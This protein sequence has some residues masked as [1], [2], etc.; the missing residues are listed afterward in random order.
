MKLRFRRSIKPPFGR[1]TVTNRNITQS[2]RTPIGTFSNPLFSSSRSRKGT[3]NGGSSLGCL[4][5]LAVCLFAA[6]CGFWGLLEFISPAATSRTNNAPATSI[7]VVDSDAAKEATS[8]ARNL[9]PAPA[10]SPDATDALQTPT[11]TSAQESPPSTI[12]STV[13]DKPKQSRLPRPRLRTWTTK[14]GSNTVNATL[15]NF[16]ETHVQLLRADNGTRVAVPINLLCLA[17]QQYVDAISAPPHSENAILHVGTVHRVKD[18]DTVDFHSV[19]GEQFTLRLEGVDA[20]ESTQQFGPEATR[21]LT[22]HV[23]GKLLRAEVTGQDRYGRALG[24]LYISK[25]WVNESLVSAGYAWHYVEYNKDIRLANAQNAARGLAKG[26]WRDAKR[27][28]PWDY[29]NGQRIATALPANVPST[30]ENEV[31]VFVTDTGT[32]YHRAGCRHLRKS[33][34]AMP[35]SRA[36]SAY[37]PCRVCH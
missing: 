8:T 31:T 17:D 6:C 32:K 11:A 5:G 7:E 12:A 1:F 3:A 13:P 14:G 29:R 20:P 34:Y 26:L 16:N 21:W 35:L 2:F 33:K 4:G 37:E 19:N 30:R 23:D 10:E 28:T 24:N 18:G 15:T 25:D 22:N 27:V 9:T 36:R